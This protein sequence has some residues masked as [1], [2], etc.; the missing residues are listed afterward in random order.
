MPALPGSRRARVDA[1]VTPGTLSDFVPVGE[2][3]V[4]RDFVYVFEVGADGH[5]HGDA[6]DAH[7]EG[8]E[9]SADVAR[10][11]LAFGVWVGREY[12]FAHLDALV[13]L[14]AEARQKVREA[15]VFGAEAA[16]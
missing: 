6:R 8:L 15:Q 11:G 12:D 14:G 2:R 9:E 7:A 10:G 5:A 13:V 3:L 16:Y 1:A 4:H